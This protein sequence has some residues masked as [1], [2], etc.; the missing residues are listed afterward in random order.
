M[1]SRFKALAAGLV[2]GLVLWS[3][4]AQSAQMYDMR[5]FL[6]QAHPF[7]RSARR[8][9]AVPVVQQPQVVQPAV[10]SGINTTL[11]TTDRQC[12]INVGWRR[13]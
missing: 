9:P 10:R 4:G 6:N 12:D 7:D 1:V 5:V 3:S 2:S 11:H 8:A 13:A